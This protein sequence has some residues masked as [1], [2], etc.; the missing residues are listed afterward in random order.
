MLHQKVINKCAKL[1]RIISILLETTVGA[2]I[3]NRLYCNTVQT[4]QTVLSV[5]S[6]L[7]FVYAIYWMMI[8]GCALSDQCYNDWVGK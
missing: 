7:F 5:L 8:V 2:E 1:R 4:V 3:Q 6:F